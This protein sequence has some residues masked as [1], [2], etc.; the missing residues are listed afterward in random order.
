MSVQLALLSLG[1]GIVAVALVALIDA[2]ARARRLRRQRA[3]CDL[4][5]LSWQQFEEVIADAFRRHGYQVREVGDR[6]QADGGV[7]MVLVRD[8]RTTLVQAKHCRRDRV[9]VQLIRE[10]Y[11]VQRAMHVQHAMLSSQGSG[12]QMQAPPHRLRRVFRRSHPGHHGTRARHH[13][14]A[15]MASYTMTFPERATSPA[16][17]SALR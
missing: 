3:L 5:A 2:V 7:D 6:G 1:A 16:P 4:A 14:S 13:S 12:S 17:A 11:G 10:R 9:G 8:G 15:Q